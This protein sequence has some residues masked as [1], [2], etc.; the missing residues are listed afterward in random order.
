MAKLFVFG[1]AH[2]QIRFNLFWVLLAAVYCV[3]KAR[4][5]ESAE[6]EVLSQASAPLFRLGTQ[7]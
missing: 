5:V 4:R 1:L 6:S 3:G 2:Q 7:Y